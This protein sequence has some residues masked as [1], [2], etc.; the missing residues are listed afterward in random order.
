MLSE[1]LVGS[2]KVDVGESKRASFY[3]FQSRIQENSEH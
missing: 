2:E 3:Y 1:K